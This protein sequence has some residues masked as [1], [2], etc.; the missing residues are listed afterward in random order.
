MKLDQFK[1]KKSLAFNVDEEAE[2]KTNST[3]KIQIFRNKNTTIVRKI[4][5]SQI[6]FNLP[7]MNDARG[8]EKLD[9]FLKNISKKK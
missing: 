3:N 2:L 9:L 6:L 5:N 8:K 1:F 4:V 7:F